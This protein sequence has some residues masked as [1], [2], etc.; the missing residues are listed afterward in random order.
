MKNLIILTNKF[1][2]GMGEQFLETEIKYWENNSFDKIY[3]LPH[4]S[5]ISIRTV[6]KN[7]ETIKNENNQNN[8]RYVALSFVSYTLYKEIFYILRTHK[9]DKFLTRSI[10]AAKTT[11]LTLKAK[12]NLTPLLKSLSNDENTIYSYWNDSTCYAACILKRKGLIDNVLS[13]AHGFDI[14]EERRA[15][16][17]MPLKRQFI[18]DF[19]KIYVLSESAS[20]YYEKTYN[21]NAKHLGIFRLGV[22]MPLNIP[23]QEYRAESISILSLS[24]C[25][26]VK[27]IHKIIKAVYEFAQ[28]NVK[29]RV[30]WIHIGGGELLS[31]LKSKSEILA[32]NQDNLSIVFLGRMKNTD[33][34]KHLSSNYY[35]VFINASKSEGVPV[36]IME[37]MSYGIP[38]IAPDVGGISDLVNASNGYLMPENFHTE[39]IIKGIKKIYDINNYKFF[40]EN[41]IKWINNNFNAKS[42]YPKFI[43]DIEILADVTY[44][45]R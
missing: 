7:I 43:E 33:V 38:A 1:P 34:H 42:N 36:S 40:R 35:D 31:Q 18:K 20:S 15:N 39:D 23:V 16:N 30:K 45:K 12:S 28:N 21:V 37:T 41:A 26:Q 6:P 17:Y 13:R 19:N 27:Q 10:S 24:N 3:I 14:Y 2:Y 4:S 22:E 5:D 11:A 44:M 9:L 32:K 29:L 25:T 8:I